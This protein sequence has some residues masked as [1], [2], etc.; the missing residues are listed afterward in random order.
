MLSYKQELEQ[1][2]FTTQLRQEYRKISQNMT[3][4]SGGSLDLR[5]EYQTMSKIRDEVKN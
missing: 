4:A 3:L 5:S 1:D 2:L